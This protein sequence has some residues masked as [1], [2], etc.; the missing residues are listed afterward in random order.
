MESL[1]RICRDVFSMKPPLSLAQFLT[2]SFAIKKLKMATEI[3]KAVGELRKALCRKK[4]ND[5]SVLPLVYTSSDGPG[6]T[7]QSRT[8]SCPS[9]SGSSVLHLPSSS[10]SQRACSDAAHRTM[11]RPKWSSSSIIGKGSGGNIENDYLSGL[12]TALNTLSN[13]LSQIVDRV[14]GIESRVF[15]IE[16]PVLKAAANRAALLANEANFKA[17][18]KHDSYNAKCG[19]SHDITGSS[20]DFVDRENH[21]QLL[22]K[23]TQRTFLDIP[24]S[25]T[26]NQLVCLQERPGMPVLISRFLQAFSEPCVSSKINSPFSSSEPSAN[27][28]APSPDR[29]KSQGAPDGLPSDRHS[30]RPVG[31]YNDSSTH[32]ITEDQ[33]D[34]TVVHNPVLRQTFK[35]TVP[36]YQKGAPNGLQLFSKPVHDEPLP[37][38]L[39]ATA[40]HEPNTSK[41]AFTMLQSKSNVCSPFQTINPMRLGSAGRS[42]DSNSSPK[43]PTVCFSNEDTLATIMACNDNSNNSFDADQGLE[44]QVNRI[45]AME[46]TTGPISPK[47][48][49]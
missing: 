49:T 6:R 10:S 39:T 31:D 40:F 34:I 18:Q 33:A 41:S 16:Q 24:H 9:L 17:K 12:L 27:A 11:R 36:L 35:K 19:D 8:F 14:A 2:K 3:V 15:A 13:Q 7:R 28:F 22:E 46:F 37:Q 23:A 45:F 1:Y 42:C 44:Q 26:K 30:P 20:L 5:C 43:H 25:Q 32:P 38:S 48:L 29:C 4:S 47:T 21:A